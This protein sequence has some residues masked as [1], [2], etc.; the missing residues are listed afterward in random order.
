MQIIFENSYKSIVFR[1]ALNLPDDHTF[2][3]AELEAMK[4]TRFENWVKAITQPPPNYK[5]GEDGEVL[6][7][8]DGNPIPA[9]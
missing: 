4:Q 1:D 6:H 8:E 9:E 3:D 7:D 2:T 5:R